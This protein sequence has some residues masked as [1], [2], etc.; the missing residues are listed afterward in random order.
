MTAIPVNGSEKAW[1]GRFAVSP[2]ERSEAFTASIRF[3]VRMVREDI[4]GSVAHVRMLGRQSII[5]SSD[6]AAIEGGL[7]QV[8]DEA[9][10]GSLIFTIK[11]EDVHT[12]VERRLREIIGA[13][14]GKL[15][16]ARSRNDQV[17][18]DARLW[19]K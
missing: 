18:N 9:T 16:T 13:A 10:D 12:G 7:W 11:D 17:A 8:W 3:D 14:Q 1:G 4:R 6:A 5:P 19:T 15:H 2:D